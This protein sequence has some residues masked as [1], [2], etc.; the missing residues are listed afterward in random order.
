MDG[1]EGSVVGL[2]AQQAVSLFGEARFGRYLSDAGGDEAR[3][4]ALCEWNQRFAGVLHSQLGYVELAVRN[5][6]DR[7]LRLL[8]EAE[9]GSPLW[10]LPGN[11][12]LLVNRLVRGQ[13]DMAR[14]RA[15]GDA[16]ARAGRGSHRGDAAVAH[17]DV[18]A[19]L[20][21]GTWVKLIGFPV[22]DGQT[23]VQRMLWDAAVRRAFPRV[24]DGEA[25]RIAVA[26]RVGYV[27]L[28]RNSE[29]HFDN[30]YPEAR[31]INRV[32][33]SM[34]SLLAGIDPALTRCLDAGLLRATARRLRV[35]L[36][37]DGSVAVAPV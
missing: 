21:W 15:Q 22:S 7:R 6:I 36:P 4:L 1:L 23:E 32:V 28:V 19:Q 10:C 8:A 5:A 11:A 37:G 33:G 27:R 25:G 14:R 29:A 35:L 20:M 24:P 3:A 12:P 18:L 30:L 2:T 34:M 26:K 13:L 9:M 16:A 31:R 17:D